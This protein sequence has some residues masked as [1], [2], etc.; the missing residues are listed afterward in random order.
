MLRKTGLEEC[1]AACWQARH[2]CQQT[3][4]QHCLP[5]GGE[6]VASAHVELMIS[7]MEICQ[8]AADAM[9]RG[10]ALHASVC[11]ACANVCDACADSCESITCGEGKPCIEMQRVADLCRICANSCRTMGQETFPIPDEALPE[12]PRMA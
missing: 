4:F 2:G 7:C 11:A 3:L 1:I 10:S 8:T 12:H 5:K 6:H 9:T